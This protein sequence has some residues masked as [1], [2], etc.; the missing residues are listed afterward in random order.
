VEQIPDPALKELVRDLQRRMCEILR[1]TGG[2]PRR[3]GLTPEG[4]AYAL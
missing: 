4:H 1:T 3:S 2:D